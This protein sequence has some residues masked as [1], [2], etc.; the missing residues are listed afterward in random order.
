MK[1]TVK[2]AT[3]DPDAPTGLPTT[4]KLADGQYAD[5]FVLSDEDRAKGRCRPLRLKYKHV[6]IRPRFPLRELLPEEKELYGGEYAKF[7]DYP[8]SEA[9]AKG[10]YW[11]EAELN[12]GCGGVTT[13]PQKCAETYAVDPSFYG[14]TFCAVCGDYFKVGAKGEFI[15]TDDGTRVGT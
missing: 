3:P 5:H 7:E 2:G 10:R 8:E 1:D 11:T 12:S 4:E 9:P 14:G 13:M 15:W 6:G